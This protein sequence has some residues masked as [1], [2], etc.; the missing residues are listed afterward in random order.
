MSW[1]ARDEINNNL[2]TSHNNNIR[3]HTH[4]NALAL[5]LAKG[6]LCMHSN[7]KPIR[8]LSICLNQ[9]FF[10][11]RWQ[12]RLNRRMLHSGALYAMY[13]VH[14]SILK[15]TYLDPLTISLCIWYAFIGHS[16]KTILV[17]NLPLKWIYSGSPMTLM[18]WAVSCVRCCFVLFCCNFVSKRKFCRTKISVGVVQNGNLWTTNGEKC[19]HNNPM[20]KM[21]ND[22]KRK[23]SVPLQVSTSIRMYE[24]NAMLER[25]RGER[26]EMQNTQMTSSLST[27]VENI[28][29]HSSS[30]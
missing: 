17:R 9:F 13:N 15:I 5:A 16:I 14:F 23:C 25:G 12:T 1:Y 26:E 11:N 2:L 10:W 24:C 7:L 18:G 29:L 22:R 3:A 19:I 21:I 8:W 4:T 6:I 20:F 30:G 28:W 27:F